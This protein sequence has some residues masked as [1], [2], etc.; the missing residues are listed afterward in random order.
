MSGTAHLKPFISLPT[1]EHTHFP[2]PH[3]SPEP[4]LGACQ[5]KHGKIFWINIRG[6]ALGGD[7]VNR[8]SRAWCGVGGNVFSLQAWLQLLKEHGFGS[9]VEQGAGFAGIKESTNSCA[10]NAVSLEEELIVIWISHVGWVRRDLIVLYSFLWF[11]MI[12]LV[13]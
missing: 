13:L 3:P 8:V 1:E 5:Q 10:S 9:L 7:W 4:C 6:G 11:F 2:A 12:L